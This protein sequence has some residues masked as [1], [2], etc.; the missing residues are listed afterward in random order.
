MKVIGITGGVGAGKSEVMTYIGSSFDAAVIQ[1][2]EVGYL[3]MQPG[4]ECYGPIIRLFGQQVTNI[5]GELNRKRIADVVFHDQEKL[6]QLNEIVHPAVKQYIKNA[7]EKERV[8]G[9]K[10][11]F[12][13]AALLI[14]DK[15]DEICDELWYIYADE[16]IRK[17]RLMSE[18]G[19]S[20]EKIKG[21]MANQLSEEEFC[22]HCAFEIDN[23]GDFEETK[24]Q[25]DQRMKKYEAL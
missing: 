13:E 6:R 3:L 18:R 11:V 25:I 23:S 5:S 4:K 16:E 17:E 10:F 15:Y 24:Q 20:D 9:T 1:A 7:I 19:Y 21:I 22:R 8:H 12:I 2:D 14:E